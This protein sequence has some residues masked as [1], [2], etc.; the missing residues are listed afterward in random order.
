MREQTQTLEQDHTEKKKKYD[1][2]V[3]QLDTEKE[4]MDKEVKSTF[5]D[6]R[7]DEKKYHQNNIQTEIYD[8]FLKRIGNES[9]FITQPDERLTN[10]FK[11]Y[12]DFFNAK[13]KQQDSIVKDLKAHQKHIKD[14]YQNYSE[15]MTLFKNLKQLL[16]V[17][18]RTAKEGGANDL[19]GYQD[20][21]A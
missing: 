6:Y 4:K 18:R 16:E 11:S 21:N 5:N 19:V 13:L 8:A 20:T 10:E 9:K 14:N 12:T 17:K 7:E 2:V 15:Q 1:S 3:N